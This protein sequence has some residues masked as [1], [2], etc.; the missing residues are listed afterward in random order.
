[1][2]QC[3]QKIGLALEIMND[4]LPRKRIGRGIDH[5]LDGH[6]LGHI[7]EMQIA[8]AVNR[9]H[10]ANANHF[11]NQIPI[12]QRRAGLQLSAGE[13]AYPQKMEA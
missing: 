12:R 1:M 11:L 4:G 7:G 10:A 2:I 9:P 5:F 13:P 6:Q 3:C 8:G